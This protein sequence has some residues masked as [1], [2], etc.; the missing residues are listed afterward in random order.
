MNK[1]AL[2]ATITDRI[3]G[4]TGVVTG[5]VEYLTGCNQL[6]VVPKVKADGSSVDAQWFDEQR[7]IVD[8]S[9][10]PVVLDNGR[11]PGCDVPAPIR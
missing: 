11:T 9:I 7:A 3:T 1:V 5:R 2:G 10:A 4:F 6:L 8:D